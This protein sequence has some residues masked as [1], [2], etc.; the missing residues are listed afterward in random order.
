MERIPRGTRLPDR[1]PHTNTSQRHRQQPHHGT[2]TE[3]TA[4]ARPTQYGPISRDRRVR[5]Q[6]CE[7]PRSMGPP[8]PYDKILNHRPTDTSIK[9]NVTLAL[10]SSIYAPYSILAQRYRQT[11]HANKNWTDLRQDIEL[12]ITNNNIGRSRDLGCRQRDRHIRDWRPTT[13]RPEQ[14]PSDSRASRTL[15]TA[16]HDAPSSNLSLH[17]NK[18]SLDYPQQYPS[19]VRAATPTSGT[20]SPAPKNAYPCSTAP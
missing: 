19:N 5:S 13:N 7:R 3:Q 9:N 1:G 18:R 11:D 17:N 12:I 8:A 14:L 16:Y 15:Y 4:F 20:P 2:R 6:R 10:G